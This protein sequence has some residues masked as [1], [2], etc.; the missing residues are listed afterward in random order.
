MQLL[1]VQQPGPF[2][3]HLLEM[4]QCQP[5]PGPAVNENMPLLPVSHIVPQHF[6]GIAGQLHYS[7]QVAPGPAVL[8][9]SGL[10]DA[11]D[12]NPVLSLNPSI[13]RI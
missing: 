12:S 7:A 8:P 4:P 5:L 6:A 13:A 9:G 1:D 11:Q 10:G 2:I 3:D